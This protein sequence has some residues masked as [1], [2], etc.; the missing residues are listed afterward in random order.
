MPRREDK[1]VRLS[2]LFDLYQ[3]TTGRL[4]FAADG[5]MPRLEEYKL[6]EATRVLVEV[7]PLTANAMDLYAR[8]AAA[9][10]DPAIGAAMRTLDGQMDS[11]IY[12]LHSRFEDELK[13]LDAADPLRAKALAL[14]KEMLPDGAV[15]VAR[16]TYVEELAAVG[17]IVVIGA[18]EQYLVDEL[19]LKRQ[20]A[21]IAKLHPEYEQ[22]LRKLPEGAP[23]HDV[24][25]AARLDANDKMLEVV[26]KIIGKYSSHTEEDIKARAYL[27]EPL[28]QQNEAM[29]ES[30][31][32]GR[33]EEDNEVPQAPE[34]PEPQP[35]PEN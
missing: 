16:A 26:A 4:K 29:A 2:G 17:R 11:S 18:R 28:I 6:A 31:R 34:A 9:R 20:L 5:M 27:L 35:V 24:V 13:T 8:W 3:L 30:L 23:H 14:F 32:L 1:L 19:G 7:G 10:N 33:R 22:M 21:K 25:K 12:V 15:A